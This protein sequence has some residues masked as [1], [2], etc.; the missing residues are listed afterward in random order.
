MPLRPLA[1]DTG[2]RSRPAI[3]LEALLLY[4]I[5]FLPGALRGDS[6]PELAVFSIKREIIRITAYN[7]PAL[8]LI[9]Y[10]WRRNRAVPVPALGDLFAFLWAFP[11]LILTS[12]SV[13]MAAA[14]F[15]GPDQGFSIG[16]PDGAAGLGLMFFSCLSTGYLEESYFRYYLGEK[17]KEAG[18]A[19]WA[20]MLIS[21]ALFALCHAYEGPWGMMNSLLAALILGL[22]YI[23][24]R[25]L[26]GLALAHGLY[27]AASYLASRGAQP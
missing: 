6:P 26:H 4:C 2:P 15:S 22:V 27:N 5:L 1:P 13:S 17:I 18:L 8:A 20:F 7:L 3:L 10:L 19:S 24:F 14:R 9:W 21:A 11:C 16:A 23:R 12:L 25:S